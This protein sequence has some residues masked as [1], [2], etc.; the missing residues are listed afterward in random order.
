M[1]CFLTSDSSQQEH[2]YSAAQQASDRGPFGV[3]KLPAPGHLAQQKGK[4]HGIISSLSLSLSL[5]INCL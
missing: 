5:L 1:L 3:L 4:G 2:S